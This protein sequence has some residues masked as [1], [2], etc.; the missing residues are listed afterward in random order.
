MK[1]LVL[2]GL[3]ILISMSVVVAASM[4]TIQFSG[5]ISGSMNT[6]F[7]TG[8][9]VWGVQNYA[10]AGQLTI[11]QPKSIGTYTIL[12]PYWA[13]GYEKFNL[14]TPSTLERFDMQLTETNY[15]NSHWD[16]EIYGTNINGCNVAKTGQNTYEITC[17]N[18]MIQTTVY[19]P[20]GVGKICTPDG[21]MCV[22]NYYIKQIMPWTFTAT[23]QT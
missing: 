15:P 21:K 9:F 18:A 3:A 5:G 4:S 1:K 20:G 6:K 22:T 23:I 14:K 13:D 12:G 7:R 17:N 11:T 19:V 2:L 8:Y 16:Y 10:P